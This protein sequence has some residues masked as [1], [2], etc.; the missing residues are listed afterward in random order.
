MDKSSLRKVYERAEIVSGDD[1]LTFRPRKS[2]PEI[3]L[4]RD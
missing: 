2:A 4:L 1:A 3:I